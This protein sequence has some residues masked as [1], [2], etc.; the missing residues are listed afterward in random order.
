VPSRPGGLLSGASYF[1]SAAATGDPAPLALGCPSPHA[2]V[3][4]LFESELEAL[5]SYGALGTIVTGDLHA[6]SISRK[7]DGGW[8]L[9]APG[10]EHPG[11]CQTVGKPLLLPFSFVHV[12]LLCCRPGSTRRPGD[13]PAWLL[14]VRVMTSKCHDFYLSTEL[15]RWNAVRRMAKGLR[16]DGG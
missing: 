3:D 7:E 13:C 14:D 5:R 1:L 10:V 6:C 4:V 12:R 2:V 15:S 8:K 11:G 16:G 9:P